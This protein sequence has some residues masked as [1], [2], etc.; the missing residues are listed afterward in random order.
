MPDFY[1]RRIMKRILIVVLAVSLAAL[2]AGCSLFGGN[3]N[4]STEPLPIVNG[5][6]VGNILNYGFCVK[7][8]DELLFQYTAGE[9]YTLGST[10][11]S[12]PNTGENSLLMED[13]GLYMNIVDG[14]LYYCKPDGIFKAEIENPEPELVLEANV[15]QLQINDGVMYY[16]EEGTLKSTTVDDKETDFSPIENADC[17]NVYGDRLYYI[18]TEDEYIY[19]CDLSGDDVKTEL[20]HKVSMFIIMDD[21]IYYL[22]GVT[23][24]LVKMELNGKLAIAIIEHALTG[25]NIN[26]SNMYYTRYISGKGTCCNADVNGGNEQQLGEFGD[27]DWHIACMYNTGSLLAKQEEME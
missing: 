2:L 16:I 26:R 13:G 18:S 4:V 6:T 21:M 22:D 15:K 1:L 8:G 23:G 11:R 24:Y 5:T 14:W 27:S 25:F 10:I 17:L 20:A 3:S 12:N 19:S 7:N 9:S